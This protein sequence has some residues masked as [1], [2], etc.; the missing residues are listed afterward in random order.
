MDKHN[1]GSME[2]HEPAIRYA[3]GSVDN[4]WTEDSIAKTQIIKILEADEEYGRTHGRDLL[5]QGELDAEMAESDREI[6]SIV[7]KQI[8]YDEAANN[9]WPQVY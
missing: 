5:T 2:V 6:K 7:R 1:N 4:D 8:K 3:G 9:L